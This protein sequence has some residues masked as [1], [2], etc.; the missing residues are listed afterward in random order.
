[1]SPSIVSPTA[2]VKSF[3]PFQRVPVI[4]QVFVKVAQRIME[5]PRQRLLGRTQVI[6]VGSGAYNPIHKLHLRMFYI[7]RK[8]LEEHTEFDVLGGLISPHHATE[9]RSRCRQRPREIIPPR[10]RLAMA[11]LAVGDSN[12]LTVDPWEITR[13]RT[14]DYLS[15]LEHVQQLFETCFAELPVKLIYL[16]GSDVLM[17][18]SP[19]DL[20]D[21]GYGCLCVCRPQETDR[22][23]RDMG[24]RWRNVAYVVEDAAILSR[25]LEMTTSLRVREAAMKGSEVVSM[26]G[27]RVAGYLKVN[28]IGPKMVGKLERWTA[29]D[30][31]F[32]LDSGISQDDRGY[33]KEPRRPL[34]AAPG[35][36]VG[37]MAIKHKHP[38]NI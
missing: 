38:F 12:W 35:E 8:Y 32:T 7:A 6:L 27:H 9:V 19:D 1:M 2:S 23:L 33:T 4:D 10:H 26:V 13:R 24:A 25:E 34:K 20:R 16:C 14:M 11:R 5:L 36:Q 3:R 22:L 21:R 29:K 28:K 30:R 37:D 17:K 18:L 15:V 31:E